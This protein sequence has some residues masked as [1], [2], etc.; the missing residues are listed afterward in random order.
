MTLSESEVLETE[1]FLLTGRLR[2]VASKLDEFNATTEGVFG[3]SLIRNGLRM[4]RKALDIYKVNNG[5]KESVRGSKCSEK[6]RGVC[7]CG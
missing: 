1:Y 7:D 3:A 4:I 6:V 5:E 2:R